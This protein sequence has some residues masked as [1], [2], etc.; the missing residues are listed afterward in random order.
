MGSRFNNEKKRRV[1]VEFDQTKIH[2]TINTDT[3]QAFS[4][5]IL[6]LQSERHN[7]KCLDFNSHTIITSSD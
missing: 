3:I 5:Y 1:S 2:Y 7:L 6:Q 4:L